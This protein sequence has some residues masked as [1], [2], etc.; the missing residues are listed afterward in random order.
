MTE[1]ELI[2]AIN[3]VLGLQISAFM[4]YLTVVSAYLIAAFVVGVRLT[5]PQ[6][7]IVSTLFIFAGI[8]IVGAIWGSGSRIA[9]MIDHLHAVDPLHPIIY[10][11]NFRNAMVVIC[12]LGIFACLKF[13]WDVRHPKI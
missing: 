13:M 12:G 2:E 1:A 7:L 3:A 4:A 6:S 5:T 9:Y 11:Y 10:S 8:L